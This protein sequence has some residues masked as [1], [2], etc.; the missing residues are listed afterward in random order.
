MDSVR[1]KQ[2]DSLLQQALAHPAEEREEYLRCASGGDDVL[3]SE[4]RSLLTSHQQTGSFLETPAIEAATETLMEDEQP[5]ALHKSIAENGSMIAHY[6][7]SGKIGA[8][9]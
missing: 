6:R 8:G 1:W 9:G 5:S 2:V 3:V 7:L 4:V